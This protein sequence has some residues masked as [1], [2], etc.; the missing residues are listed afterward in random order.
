MI[1]SL[2]TLMFWAVA[3]PLAALV[4]FPWT[5][6]TRD[7]M[8][9][10]RV[11]TWIAWTG[12][13][14]AGVRVEVVGRARLDAQRSYLYMSNHTSNL[15][16]PL[17]IPLIPKRTSVLVKK[18]LFRIPVFGQA[19]RIGSLV[20]VDRSNRERAIESLR[21]AHSVLKSGI[22]MTIFVEGTRSRDGR[23]LP[24]KKGPFYLAMDTGVPIVPVTIAGT[25]DLL[26]K[27]R[28][29]AR[30]GTVRVVFHEPVDPAWFGDDRDALVATVRNA[31][32]SALPR[33]K[34]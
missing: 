17:L 13:R 4:M 5:L 3:T 1:R 6:L 2:F 21:Q 11:G 15:D 29:F 20:P 27:G 9:L 10:Y 12:V 7:I 31:I 8:P 30:P 24:F 33:E 22:S 18:E 32:A 23:L 14:I 28:I 26:P 25:Y 34:Q 16:P 19:M